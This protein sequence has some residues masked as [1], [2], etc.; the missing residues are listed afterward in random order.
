MR[1]VSRSEV[2]NPYSSHWTGHWLITTGTGS[3]A[4]MKAAMNGHVAQERHTM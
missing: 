2:I 3:F 1:L 4:R